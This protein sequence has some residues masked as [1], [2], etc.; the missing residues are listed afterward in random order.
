MGQFE[1]TKLLTKQLDI[2][3]VA[4][5]NVL[6]PRTIPPRLR[7][8]IPRLGR[9]IPWESPQGA[10]HVHP[11]GE[12]QSRTWPQ[13]NVT[14]ALAAVRP[15]L[16]VASD[17]HGNGV[18]KAIVTTGADRYPM[19]QVPFSPQHGIASSPM[20]R[21][22]DRFTFALTAGSRVPFVLRFLGKCHCLLPPIVVRI[23]LSSLNLLL[24]SVIFGQIVS[25]APL[26]YETRRLSRGWDP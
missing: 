2:A 9:D 5:D 17:A 26:S 7:R 19:M 16:P 15:G 23:L 14:F 22:S 11:W 1:V 24:Q 13:E 8:G 12:R 4:E 10:I 18:T 25:D 3:P 20:V 21:M 6:S